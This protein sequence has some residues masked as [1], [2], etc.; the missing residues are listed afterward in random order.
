MMQ[1]ERELRIRGFGPVATPHLWIVLD[2]HSRIVRHI[3]FRDTAEDLVEELCRVFLRGNP[4]TPLVTDN[5]SARRAAR[6]G[7][8]GDVER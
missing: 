8:Q 2:S 6:K 4:P 1:I 5:G 7:S 3:L